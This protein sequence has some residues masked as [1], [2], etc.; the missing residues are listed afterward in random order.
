MTFIGEKMTTTTT[1]TVKA[2]GMVQQA[3]PAGD[4]GALQI[5]F[6]V[7]NAGSDFVTWIGYASSTDNI[8]GDGW[9]SLASADLTPDELDLIGY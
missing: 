9:V 8:T 5:V 3:V 4:Y 6:Q 2:F 7:T 1:L